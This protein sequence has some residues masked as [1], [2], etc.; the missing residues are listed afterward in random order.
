MDGL[1][2]P[3]S[4]SRTEAP[5]LAVRTECVASRQL[6]ADNAG[7]AATPT[8]SLIVRARAATAGAGRAGHQRKGLGRV[9]DGG[10][11]RVAAERSEEDV[12]PAVG[13]EGAVSLPDRPGLG[14]RNRECAHGAEP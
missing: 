6:L 10:A 12:G 11:G 2:L 7:A 8:V 13:A 4:S 3:P 1:A 14:G 5:G 9:E